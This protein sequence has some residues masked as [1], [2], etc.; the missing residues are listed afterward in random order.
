VTTLGI[1]PS[2]AAQTGDTAGEAPA[3]NLTR[4]GLPGN[5]GGRAD[6]HE[7]HAREVGDDGD[8]GAEQ[9]PG[10]GTQPEPVP[11]GGPTRQGDTCH[12]RRDQD[13]AGHLD[14]DAERQGGTRAAGGRLRREVHGYL[15][16]A[17][18]IIARIRLASSSDTPRP[19]SRA[20]TRP[21]AEPPK[22]V[23]TSRRTTD[24]SVASRGDA[25]R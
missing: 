2:G 5:W 9:D 21:S 25:A 6:R 10:Q 18:S 17:F 12:H 14:D 24:P 1:G 22:A 19:C 13:H 3:S 7:F 23:S 8:D 11:G 16:S 4:P 15:P 20:M